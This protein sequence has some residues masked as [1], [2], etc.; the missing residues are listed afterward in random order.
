[1]HVVLARVMNMVKMIIT[2][3]ELSGIQAQATQGLM[4]MLMGNGEQKDEHADK[5][6]TIEQN[7]VIPKNTVLPAG[8]KIVKV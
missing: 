3:F 6:K 2:S 1:M 4:G 8:A 7:A 5:E